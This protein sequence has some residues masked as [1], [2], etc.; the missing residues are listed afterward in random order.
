M[1]LMLALMSLLLSWLGMF[2]LLG[3][4]EDLLSASRRQVLIS[5]ARS[6]VEECL[7]RI[8]GS[9]R[10]EALL[11]WRPLARLSRVASGRWGLPGD[12]D[13]LARTSAAFVLLVP[14]FAL[15][16]VALSRAPVAIVVI[17]TAIAGGLL[18][19]D[20]ARE[21][22]LAR[23]LAEEMPSVFR[24]MSVALGSGQTLS[25]AVAY[26]GS[27][28]KGPAAHEFFLTSLRLQAGVSAE[29]ALGLMAEELDA[30]GVDLMVTALL[31]SQRTGSPLRDLFQRSARLV[32]RQGEFERSLMVKT[33]QVRL[34]VRI[35]CTLPLI[36]IGVLSLISPD[37]Q[38]GLATVPGI[39]SV[40]LALVLD[41]VALLVIRRIMR[42]VL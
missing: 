4:G 6:L 2:A 27:H 24:T 22:A 36:M 26:V 34:S 30:P 7:A 17:P 21:R 29:D 10:L 35:V 38:S 41:G 16:G 39:V 8:S 40:A 13:S 32:E 12:D 11:H 3:G 20:G 23:E 18:A 42:E 33:A 25:Q 28:E 15:L 1:A 5:R 31:I 37:F 19:W 9:S 14:V